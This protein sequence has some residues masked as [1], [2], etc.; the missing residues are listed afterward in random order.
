MSVKLRVIAFLMVLTIAGSLA[1]CSASKWVMKSGEDTVS[2]GVY[3]GYLLEAYLEAY[4]KSDTS[5]DLLTQKIEEKPAADWIVNKAKVFSKTYLAV[6]QK[7]KELNLSLTEED[8]TNIENQVNSFWTQYGSVY[9]DNGCSKASYTLIFTNSYKASKIF[10]K[11]YD[12]GGITPAPE[13]DV[14]KYFQ[15]NFA[16]VKYIAMPLVLESGT[17]MTDA[18][19]EEVRK[20]ASGYLDRAKAGEDFDKIIEE[21]QAKQQ[22]TSSLGS[23]ETSSAASSSA[24]ASQDTSS[25]T[26]EQIDEELREQAKYENIIDKG[27]T[28][29]PAA[30]VE[31]VFKMTVGGYEI[32]EA[33]Q[34]CL[35]T[36]R[37]DV[38][39]HTYI[40][41]DYRKSALSK[42]KQPEFEKLLEEFMTKV[43]VT[44]NG[45][46][47][48]RYK[49]KNIKLS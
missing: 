35:V 9:E 29:Y 8:K 44:E 10:E 1:G 18:E 32:I 49:P 20:E 22:G 16:R 31:G 24:T 19:K 6:E 12:E 37:L 34:Y 41:K 40:Y 39:E 5:K 2:S 7:M 28:Q 21:Y 15:E 4:N 27:N 48:S 23:S 45:M 14:K 42:M 3:L 25:K 47:I 36:T 13:A 46:A 30:F 33:D 43:V 26:Q 17:E 11:Y 38:N